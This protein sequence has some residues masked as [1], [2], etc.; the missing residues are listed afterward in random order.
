MLIMVLI[1]VENVYLYTCLDDLAKGYKMSEIFK[2]Y[3][4]FFAVN[5]NESVAVFDAA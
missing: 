5:R 1:C 3:I 2:L 4:I